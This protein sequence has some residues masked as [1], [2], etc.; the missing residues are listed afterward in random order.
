MIRMITSDMD[1]TLLAGS[2]WANR[3]LPHDFAETLDELDRRGIHFLAASG[4]AYP[5]VRSNFGGLADRVDYIC[6][7]GGCLVCGGQVVHV[8]EVP[9][10]DAYAFLDLCRTLPV[11]PPFL[12]SPRGMFMTVEEHWP[13]SERERPWTFIVPDLRQVEEPLTKLTVRTRPGADLPA[14]R[15]PGLGPAGYSP[16]LGGACAYAA[17]AAVRME[18][19]SGR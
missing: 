11:E 13:G 10:P 8:A 14:L 16:G 6:D 7:N 19:V 3:R 4:R 15:V 9:K 17:G 18:E 2:D 12:T 5:S 1:G